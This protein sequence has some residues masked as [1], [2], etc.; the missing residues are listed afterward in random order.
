MDMD[1]IKAVPVTGVSSKRRKQ[2]ENIWEVVGRLCHRGFATQATAEG[3]V[4]LFMAMTGDE[5]YYVYML[6][7]ADLTPDDARL[8]AQRLLEAADAAALKRP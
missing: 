1:L 6:V 2:W 5:K 7:G 8:L 3:N 4:R